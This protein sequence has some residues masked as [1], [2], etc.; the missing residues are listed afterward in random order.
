MRQFRITITGNYN[1]NLFGYLYFTINISN[2][3]IEGRNK[4]VKDILSLA[5]GYRNF[6]RFRNRVLYVFNKHEKPL[7][8]PKDTK[9]MKLP[10]QIRGKYKKR[11]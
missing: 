4:Y 5:N 1:T 2:G 8:E 10:G 6:K 3:P 7:K 9:L 11:K